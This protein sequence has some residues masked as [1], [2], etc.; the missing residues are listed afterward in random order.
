MALV[1]ITWQQAGKQLAPGIILR[2]I[3]L[4]LIAEHAA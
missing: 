1:E 3:V 2:K 4:F